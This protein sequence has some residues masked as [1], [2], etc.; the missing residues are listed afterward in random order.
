MADKK[1]NIKI[2][3]LVLISF[4]FLFMFYKTFFKSKQKGVQTAVRTQTPAARAVIPEPA[5]AGQTQTVTLPVTGKD[6]TENDSYTAPPFKIIVQ[7]IFKPHETEKI[8]PEKE[9]EKDKPK[10]VS[11][12]VKKIVRIMES[13]P[14]S[15]EEKASI[16]QE[17]NFTGS[18]LSSNS[19]V[20]IINSEF[21]H[22]GDQVNGYK[23]ESISERHVTIDTGRGKIIL[24]IM[25][26]D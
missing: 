20:A 15:E 24:E 4:V 9:I 25:T 18:I 12:A 3:A 14:L 10:L 5:P 22:V 17:L 11:Q 6:S 19:A 13:P 7:D 21:I 2:I 16:S 1:K 23:V 8:L 26:H